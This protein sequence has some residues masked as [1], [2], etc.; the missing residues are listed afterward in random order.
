MLYSYDIGK[1]HL[2]SIYTLY[3]MPVRSQYERI[4]PD[5]LQQYYVR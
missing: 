2:D 3:Y 1:R 4:S 5:A